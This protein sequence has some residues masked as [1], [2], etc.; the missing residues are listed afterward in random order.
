MKSQLNMKS[1]VM[2]VALAQSIS[3][4]T[5][6]PTEE[7]DETSRYMYL[8]SSFIFKTMESRYDTQFDQRIEEISNK[9]AL[10]LESEVN[11]KLANK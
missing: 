4:V 10:S 3:G 5:H 1:L 7:K 11:Q 9:V 6:L 2:T 8:D